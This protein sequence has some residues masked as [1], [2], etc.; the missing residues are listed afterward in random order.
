MDSSVRLIKQLLEE[1]GYQD[2][3]MFINTDNSTIRKIAQARANAEK[4]ARINKQD[5][6]LLECDNG[7]KVYARLAR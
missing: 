5:I 6:R 1:M 4:Y 7:Y 2:S 3:G